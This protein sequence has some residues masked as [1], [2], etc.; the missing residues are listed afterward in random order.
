MIR[1]MMLCVACAGLSVAALAQE[2]PQTYYRTV[3][4]LKVPANTE[5]AYLE[6]LRTNTRRILR[7][8]MESGAV[9]NW[10]V[11]KLVYEGNSERAYNYVATALYAGP[12]VDFSVDEEEQMLR[13]ATGISRQEYVQKISDLRTSVGSMLARMDAAVPGIQPKE[14]NYVSVTTWKLQAQQGDDYGDYVRTR[15]LPLQLENFKDGRHIGWSAGR[16]VYPSGADVEFDAV[17]AI[18]RMDLAS[19]VQVP[20]AEERAAQ[21]AKALPSENYA[22]FQDR[23]RS[24]RRRVRTELFKV[25]IVEAASEQTSAT[26]DQRNQ[27]TLAGTP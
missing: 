9:V 22:A 26:P 18:I 1:R 16:V 27:G 15:L 4:F 2:S 14:G 19:A 24:L 5:Q 20:L 11:L 17:T 8:G 23:G 10:S 25:M 21:F 6:F 3:Q 12:P 13:R 7:V